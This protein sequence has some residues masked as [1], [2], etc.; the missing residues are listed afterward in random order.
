VA[1]TICSVL[2]ASEGVEILGRLPDL[3][4]AYEQAS[5]VIAP[6]LKG[7]GIK[8]KILEAISFGRACITTSVGAEGL[9]E[10]RPTLDVCDDADS[11]AAVAVRY[12]RRSEL[13]VERGKQ[14]AA[15][16]EKHLSSDACYDPVAGL[17]R[18][19]ANA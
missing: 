19:M 9:E 10:F 14:L 1:G 3:T 15:L 13:A 8:I 12:L 4:R 16:A 6:L 2:T 5:A 7:S 11:F 17:L 18:K